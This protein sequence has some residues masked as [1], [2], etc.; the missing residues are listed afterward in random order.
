[1]G[2]GQD[3]MYARLYATRGKYHTTHGQVLSSN[4]GHGHNSEL[5]ALARTPAATLAARMY[6]ESTQRR[7]TCR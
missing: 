3:C 4:A 2:T 1:M 6:S 5:E 7:P